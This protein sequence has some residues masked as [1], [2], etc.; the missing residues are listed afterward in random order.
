MKSN[1]ETIR[2][3]FARN[4]KGYRTALQYSQEKLAEK[5]GLAIQTIKDIEAGR[6]WVSDRSLS[7]LSK[8]LNIAEFQLLLPDMYDTFKKPSKANLEAIIT[9]KEKIKT[10]M[11]EQFEKTLQNW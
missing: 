2:A 11:D 9:L 8:A 6:R 3:V 4:V 1:P 10:F 7:K 5:S